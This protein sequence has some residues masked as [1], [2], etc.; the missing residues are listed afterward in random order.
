MSEWTYVR[1]GLTFGCSPFEVDKNFKEV[2]PKR[3]YF[4]SD[5]AYE[6]AREGYKE[7][8]HKAVYLPFPEEQFKLGSPVIGHNHKTDKP[9]LEFD[10]TVVYSLPRAKPILEAAFELFPQGETG[11]RHTLDQRN[12]DG[13]SSMGG[14]YHDCMQGYYQAAIDKMYKGFEQGEFEFWDFDNLKRYVGVQEDC[15]W[16]CA[17][18]IVCGIMT[19]LRDATAEEV[20][21]S[22]EEFIKYLTEHDISIDQGYLE[23]YDSYCQYYKYRWAFRKGEWNGE[24]AIMKLDWVT[25]EIIWKKAHVHPKTADGKKID[26]SRFDDVCSEPAKPLSILGSDNIDEICK[27]LGIKEP[28][29]SQRKAAEKKLKLL[30][31]VFKDE[32]G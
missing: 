3:A 10:G 29:T 28:T 32:Q 17:S 1:G 21:E 20:A 13:H 30:K 24:Y 14:F 19:S 7:R 23:W 12:T 9:A 16:Y 11:F 4:E 5:A 25:N 27:A 26:F 2:E 18:E 6:A 22:L 31:K 15:N 8:W